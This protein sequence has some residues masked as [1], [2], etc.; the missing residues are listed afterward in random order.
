MTHRDP[1]GL[2]HGTYEMLATSQSHHPPGIQGFYWNL[3]M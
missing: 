3:D 2:N 1:L